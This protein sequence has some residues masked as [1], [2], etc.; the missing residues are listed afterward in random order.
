MQRRTFTLEPRLNHTKRTK[1][2]LYSRPIVAFREKDSLSGSRSD[3]LSLGSSFTEDS[4][5]RPD[6]VFNIRVLGQTGGGSR[7]T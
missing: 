3:P 1:Q 7:Q 2:D 5:G 4:M 6:D